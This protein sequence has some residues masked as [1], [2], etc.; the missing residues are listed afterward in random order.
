[1]QKDKT[2]KEMEVRLETLM[3]VSPC[4][5]GGSPK[6]IQHLFKVQIPQCSTSSRVTESPQVIPIA[7]F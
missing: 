7:S 4:T 3:K 6:Q 5:L 1:M 2:G